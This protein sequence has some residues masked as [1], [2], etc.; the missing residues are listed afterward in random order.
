MFPCDRLVGFD[1]LTVWHR[2]NGH[3]TIDLVLAHVLF[4]ARG[5]ALTD[6]LL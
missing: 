2:W 1:R 3:A 6:R 5:Y 4:T